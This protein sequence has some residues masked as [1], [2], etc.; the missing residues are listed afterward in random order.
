LRVRWVTEI[1]V[2]GRLPKANICDISKYT[3]RRFW[4]EQNDRFKEELGYRFKV[5]DKTAV[6]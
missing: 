1:G 3:F 4:L 2:K 6:P 5:D